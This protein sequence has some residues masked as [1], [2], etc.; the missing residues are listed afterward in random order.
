MVLFSECL[1][2]LGQAILVF[3]GRDNAFRSG[4]SGRVSDFYWLQNTSVLPR[5]FMLESGEVRCQL[6]SHS[7]AYTKLSFFANVQSKSSNFC[8]FSHC[9]IRYNYFL[10]QHNRR[11]SSSGPLS[12]VMMI[13]RK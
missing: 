8:N 7:L 11:M 1:A 10:I 6:G 13:N 5:T 9:E 3:L 2:L 12:A 4:C